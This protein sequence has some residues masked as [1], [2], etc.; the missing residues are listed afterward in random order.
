MGVGGVDLRAQRGQERALG[1]V[2]E[3][4]VQGARHGRGV[5]HERID[6]DQEL[7]LGVARVDVGEGVEGVPVRGGVDQVEG[8]DL[9]PVGAQAALGRRLDAAAGVG[10]HVGGGRLEQVGDDEAAGL[11]GPRRPDDERVEVAP[12][13]ARVEAEALGAGEQQVPSGIRVHHRPDVTGAAPPRGAVL[14]VGPDV[15]AR[16]DA[17]DDGEE[18]RC[19]GDH[20]RE[21][22][23]AVEGEVREDGE[24]LPEAVEHVARCAAA[25]DDGAHLVADLVAD[26]PSQNTQDADDHRG[27]HARLVHW[28]PPSTRGRLR[29]EEGPATRGR[30]SARLEHPTPWA[31]Q[32]NKYRVNT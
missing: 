14:L 20:A 12:G 16:A 5:R 1:V 11:A 27:P 15:G 8:P 25:A 6:Q 30:R 29:G 32:E 3:G 10:D 13:G 4:V 23:G 2:A 7:D 21:H 17:V 22:V 28:S 24:V 18:H 19:G 31:D 9:V 26:G